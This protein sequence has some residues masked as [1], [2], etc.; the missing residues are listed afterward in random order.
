MHYE[1]RGDIGAIRVSNYSVEVSVANLLI[2]TGR[3]GALPLVASR[4]A[5]VRRGRAVPVAAVVVVALAVAAAAAAAAV[6]VVVSVA[7]PVVSIIASATYCRFAHVDA[8]SGSVSSLCYGIIDADAT[9]VNFHSGAFI[10]CNLSIFHVLKVNE[11]KPSGT[12]RLCINYNL[13]FV[14]GSILRK[15]MV[16]LLF[17]CIKTKSKNP[18]A[19]RG[20]RVFQKSHPVTE[21]TAPG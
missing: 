1:A 19:P 21:M 2:T 20:G 14:N 7:A 6:V 8:R 11:A 15:D 10:L 12:A 9:T 18:E 5:V 3:V 16:Y 13:H 17:S 4:A